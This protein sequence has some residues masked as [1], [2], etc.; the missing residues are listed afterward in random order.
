[1]PANGRWDLIRRLKVKEEITKFIVKYKDKI[2]KHPNE[3]ISTL[4]DVEEPRRLQRFKP[5]DLTD[6]FS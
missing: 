2:T 4:L 1:M 5:T 3:L 6:R